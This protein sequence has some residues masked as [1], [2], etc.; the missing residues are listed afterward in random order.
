MG[1]YVVRSKGD[2]NGIGTIKM[3]NGGVYTGELKNGRRH[4]QGVTIYADGWKYEGQYCNS[5]K[6][7]FGTLYLN[8]GI[9]Y[10]GEWKWG[11]RY[12]QRHDSNDSLSLGSSFDSR[13]S[14]DS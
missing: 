8:N 6:H 12:S 13:C 3:L 4:G 7:G 1:N 9:M 5:K 2:M 11:Q 14:M 10:S